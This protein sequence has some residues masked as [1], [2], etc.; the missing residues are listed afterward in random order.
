MRGCLLTLGCVVRGAWSEAAWKQLTVLAKSFE[1]DVPNACHHP[2]S[3]HVA[4]LGRSI[5]IL[6]RLISMVTRPD[7]TRFEQPLSSFPPAKQSAPQQLSKKICCT[8]MKNDPQRSGHSSR[9]VGCLKC[10]SY[11]S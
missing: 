5:D 2:D 1:I 6:T 9:S 4:A 3:V 10:A 7:W 8:V 11:I